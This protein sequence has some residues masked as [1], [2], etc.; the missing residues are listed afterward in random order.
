MVQGEALEW[1]SLALQ[2]ITNYSDPVLILNK[3]K[4]VFRP[5]SWSGLLSETMQNRLCLLSGFKKHS[6]LSV[7]SWASREERALEEEIRSQRN[8][9]LKRESNLNERFE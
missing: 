8:K 9:E 4:L 3:F 7:S 2:L 6:D 5:N 1:T